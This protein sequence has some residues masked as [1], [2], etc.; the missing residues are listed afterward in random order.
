MTSGRNIINRSR[1][2]AV[3][4]VWDVAVVSIGGRGALLVAFALVVAACGGTTEGAV[5]N[6]TP[7]TA[8]SDSAVGEDAAS[9]TTTDAEPSGDALDQHQFGC[10]SLDHAG[11]VSR[12]AHPDPI[13]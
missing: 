9:P 13:C 2:V 1:L 4:E 12:Q 5:D 11:W 3:L 7:T 6:A 10:E 8:P